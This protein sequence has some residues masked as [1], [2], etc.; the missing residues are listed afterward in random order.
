MEITDSLL[1]TLVRSRAAFRLL[2]A[3][4]RIH[5]KTL[6][7]YLISLAYTKREGSRI[8]VLYLPTLWLCLL[9]D[10]VHTTTLGMY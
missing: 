4:K 9:W 5:Y 7:T 2:G 6:S 1:C 10:K 3:W 8:P